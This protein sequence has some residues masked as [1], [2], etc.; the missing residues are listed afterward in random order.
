MQAV[1]GKVV[2]KAA[3]AAALPRPHVRH[4]RVCA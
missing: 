2:H 3:R 4:P 1:T